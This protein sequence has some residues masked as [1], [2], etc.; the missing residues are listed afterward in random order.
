ME[1]SGAHTAGL[2][3][4]SARVPASRVGRAAGVSGCQRLRSH[5][6]PG[7]HSVPTQDRDSERE[8]TRG[9]LHRKW[10]Q[11]RDQKLGLAL[12]DDQNPTCSTE[13]EGGWQGLRRAK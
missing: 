10:E 2:S 6:D 3:V 9:Q 13:G 7:G 1:R 11:H 5:K 8:A 4:G 12:R